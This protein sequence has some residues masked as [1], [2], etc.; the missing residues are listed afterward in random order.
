VVR[1]KGVLAK[2]TLRGS[3]S[4][5][6]RSFI[7]ELGER[8]ALVLLASHSTCTCM[9]SLRAA[10]DIDAYKEAEGAELHADGSIEL[11][12]GI[13]GKHKRRITTKGNVKARF[14]ND[15]AVD[16]EGA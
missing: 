4:L 3:K 16:R 8:L 2:S 13:F 6:L 7:V 15:S 5:P 12:Q 14:L 1:R 9:G 11:K 10:D